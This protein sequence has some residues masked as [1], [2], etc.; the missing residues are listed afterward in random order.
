MS[1]RTVFLSAML[2]LAWFPC[3]PQLELRSVT[4]VVTDKRGN[5]LPGAAVQ[6]ENTNNLSV[7][8]YMTDKDGRYHF[9]GLNDDIDY[10]LKAKYRSYWAKPKTLSKF[11]SSKNPELDLVIPIE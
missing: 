9:T 4:G 1:K 7:R 6:L 3:L 2:L 8:S 11:D 5:P 10:T